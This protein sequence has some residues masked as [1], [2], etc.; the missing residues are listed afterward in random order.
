MLNAHKFRTSNNFEHIIDRMTGHA[1]FAI[2]AT[3][4]K[5]KA[6]GTVLLKT[7]TCDQNFANRLFRAKGWDVGDN[8]GRDECPD[9]V[10]AGKKAKEEKR[11]AERAEQMKNVTPLPDL[12]KNE[13]NKLPRASD[14]EV[15]FVYEYIKSHSVA[16][17]DGRQYERGWNDERIAFEL[18]PVIKNISG[19][20]VKNI[21]RLRFGAFIKGKNM[22]QPLVK[23]V[24]S[25]PV[26]PPTVTETPKTEAPPPA[27]VRTG[28]P[29]VARLK[30][31]DERIAKLES[32]VN[33]LNEL[34]T[35]MKGRIEELSD[36][37]DSLMEIE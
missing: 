12:S 14:E 35:Q 27:P 13:D 1:R 3:C 34:V 30:A 10:A 20:K 11:A 7:H 2:K 5:C 17:E 18:L 32:M 4:H 23:V 33:A 24:A 22:S 28:N 15:Q 29:L 36:D 25:A 37:F 26:A 8:R 21:R 19:A 9:C 31:Q 16:T 6:T